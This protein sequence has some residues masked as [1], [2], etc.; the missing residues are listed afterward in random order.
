MA[1]KLISKANAAEPPSEQAL[2]NRIVT[3]LEEARTHVART[4]NSAMV[5]AYWLIGRE[6]VQE[7]QAGDAR[8]A[9]GKSVIKDLSAR[10]QK[11]YGKGFSEENL[12][13]FR[14]FYIVIAIDLQ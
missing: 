6:I 5:I 1:K 12:R 13:W 11:Q 9:Y 3:I 8:A 2:F 7:L 14:K 10:L 4:V